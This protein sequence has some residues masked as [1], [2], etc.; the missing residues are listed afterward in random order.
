VTPG[1]L[2]TTYGLQNTQSYDQ[3][4]FAVRVDASGAT[5]Y[6][7]YIG[8]MAPTNGL[9]LVIDGAGDAFVL[10]ERRPNREYRRSPAAIL[11]H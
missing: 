6:A 3:Q 2:Q 4:A 9:G 5:N 10:G 8:G 7:T 11:R 1:A